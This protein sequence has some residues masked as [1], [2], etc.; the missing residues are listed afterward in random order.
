MAEEKDLEAL[1]ERLSA[2]RKGSLGEDSP[3][4]AVKGPAAEK[5][6][7]KA[8]KTSKKP[9]YTKGKG[10]EDAESPKGPVGLDI[11]TSHIV[12]AQNK[13]NYVNL[14]QELNAFFTVPSAKFAREI[15]N[16]KD[17]KFYEWEDQYYIFGYSAESFANMFNVNTRR[18][19]KD[20]FLSP[21]EDED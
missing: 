12:V 2:A 10:D 1:Q 13:R 6:M 19:M 3:L 14:V 8:V 20:G 21:K 5:R 17:V 18:S 7:K 4:K 11:G 16:Q 9:V 15:L